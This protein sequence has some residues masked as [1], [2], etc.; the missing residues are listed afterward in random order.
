MTQQ[1]TDY[2]SGTSLKKA[3]EKL[4]KDK[5]TRDDYK[6]LTILSIDRI[7]FINSKDIVKKQVKKINIKMKSAY[8]LKIDWLRYS[9]SVAKTAYETTNGKCVSHQIRDFLLNPPT[10]RPTKFVNKVRT[11]KAIL[12]EDDGDGVSTRQVAQLCKSIKRNMYAYGEDDK[13]FCKEINDKNDHY[14]PIVFYKVNGHMYIINDRDAILSVKEAN[15][16]DE[17]KLVKS[18][19]VVEKKSKSQEEYTNNLQVR[20]INEFDVNETMNYEGAVIVKQHDINHDMKDAISKFQIHP[21]VAMCNDSFVGFSYKNKN[22]KTVNVMC[23]ANHGEDIC[24]DRLRNVATKNDIKY[25]NEGIGA[26]LCNLV[27]KSLKEDRAYLT[28]QEKEQIIQDHDSCCVLCNCKSNK[29]QIDHI[30]PLGNG[31]TNDF[32]NLQ[33][34][35][36]DCHKEKTKEENQTGYKASMD[37]S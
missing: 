26:V 11:E 1:W 4:V 24:Y 30:I 8:M 12:F 3:I 28:E 29:L 2:V 33:L 21:K 31:G 6:K 22:E 16:N 19:M 9:G 18:E 20:Y 15:K 10:N 13:C 35:C 23:D 7:D 25:I 34:I 32:D 5:E 17:M 37:S 27:G 14:C 36:I